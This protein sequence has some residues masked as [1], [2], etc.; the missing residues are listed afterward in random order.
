[1]FNMRKR[2]VAVAGLLAALLLL[3][4]LFIWFGMYNFA[5]DVAHSRPVF[6][7][8]ETA[9]ERSVR[10]RAENIKAPPLEDQALVI[11]GAGNYQAMCAQCH[12]APGQ[13]ATE[14]SRGLYPSPP[15]LAKIAIDP[16]IAFWTIKHGIKASGM[17]AWGKSMGDA[18]IWNLVA[19]MKKL[20][21]MDA[22]TY[23]ELVES[24]S[25]HSHAGT[26][27]PMPGMMNRG[28]TEGEHGGHSAPASTEPKSES[29]AEA[30]HKHAEGEQH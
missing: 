16:S 13:K 8:I 12:L 26:P 17:P 22:A 18:D 27:D 20:P 9:R 15:E 11:K 21:G 29:G 6:S 7:L 10:V 25:G 28:E 19:F 1:M 4:V 14:L 2:L 5:A 23:R 3:G 30:A 24:S